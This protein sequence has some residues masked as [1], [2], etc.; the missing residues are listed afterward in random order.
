MWRFSRLIR[1]G[2][3]DRPVAGRTAQRWALPIVAAW[4][5]LALL[6]A[7]HAEA[8]QFRV[9]FST[10]GGWHSGPRVCP[11]L[12]RSHQHRF[13]SRGYHHRPP[14]VRTFH[15]TPPRRIICHE[16]YAPRSRVI[17][18]GRRWRGSIHL[19]SDFHPYWHTTHRTTHGVW[20]GSGHSSFYHGRG[21][22]YDP[23]FSRPIDSGWVQQTH[24]TGWPSPPVDQ[25]L[26]HAHPGAP[27]TA[28]RDHAEALTRQAESRQAQSRQAERDPS[29]LS[30]L[31]RARL[32]LSQDSPGRAVDLYREHLM[33]EP[34]DQEARRELALAHLRAGS[35]SEGVSLMHEAYLRNPALA[36]RPM[37]ADL[38]GG[39]RAAQRMRELV[40]QSV[41]RA[42]RE[43]SAGAWL[44][45][46]VLM[47]AEGRD[48][49]ALRM[50][51]NS[52]DRGLESAVAVPLADS[53]R[54]TAYGRGG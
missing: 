45:A 44:V 18:D 34:G 19:G 7:A 32:A 47:Q 3:A 10:G 2:K 35:W 42:H 29:S 38:L 20:I 15:R 5:T 24:G 22:V 54:R 9:K 11:T 4:A 40:R 46:A 28:E 49:P 51:V 17:Y 48:Q 33:G 16:V 23:H 41:R 21:V 12:G 1:T 30:R 26:H 50:V 43:D 25:R 39:P 14:S 31:D 13:R 52:V 36:D 27:S 6:G 37:R 53:M 8:Q